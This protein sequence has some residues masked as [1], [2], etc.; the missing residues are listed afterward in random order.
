MSE[1]TKRVDVINVLE[2]ELSSVKEFITRQSSMAKMA[3]PPATATFNGRSPDFQDWLFA[4]DLLF[5]V[6]R[7]YD[8]DELKIGYAANLFRGSALKGATP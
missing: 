3:S 1:L 2:H 8:R 7:G 4:L 6:S 5:R